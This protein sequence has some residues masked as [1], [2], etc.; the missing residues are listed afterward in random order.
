[1]LKA[2]MIT[3][4]TIL[5][6]FAAIILHRPVKQYSVFEIKSDR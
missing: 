6:V 5:A 1:M 3:V 2:I 4:L